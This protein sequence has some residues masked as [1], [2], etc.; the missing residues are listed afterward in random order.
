M[1]CIAQFLPGQWIDAHI[2]GIPQVGGFSITST[3]RDVQR[4]DGYIELAIQ[5]AAQNPP[6]AWFWR[7]IDDVKQDDIHV[8]VG[9]SFV[10]PPIG[11]DQSSITKIIFVAGGVG[12]KWVST[13][14][15][16]QSLFEPYFRLSL[17]IRPFR[18]SNDW[19]E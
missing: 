5:R 15:I 3:P 16:F 8:R 4:D 19:T 12:I 17:A 11:I 9:G 10:W 2:P 7:Q 6:A 18:C 1:N 14:R 13:S